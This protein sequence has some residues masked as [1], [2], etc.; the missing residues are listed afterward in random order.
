MAIG[1]AAI[2]AARRLVAH[3]L[4]RQRQDELMPMLDTFLDRRVFAVVA[5]DF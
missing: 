2:H 3:F 4:L 5:V 1:H